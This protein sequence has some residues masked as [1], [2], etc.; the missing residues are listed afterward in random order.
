MNEKLKKI[1][2]GA[3]IAILGAV[4]TYAANVVVPFLEKDGGMA[5]PII[6]A[7]VAI[8]INAARK[9]LEQQPKDGETNG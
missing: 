6:A 5:G 2:T 3:A 9:F 1:L 8:A 4:V 7:V